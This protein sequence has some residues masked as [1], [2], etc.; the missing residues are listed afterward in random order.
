MEELEKVLEQIDKILETI[1]AINK[2]LKKKE[3]F[4]EAGNMS[5]SRYLAL[6][7]FLR[8]GLPITVSFILSK[9]DISY[10]A[11]FE[12]GLM[13]CWNKRWF[14]VLGAIPSLSAISLTVVYSPPFT[15]IYS[16]IHILFSMCQ[17]KYND[18]LDFLLHGYK[19]EFKKFVK[20]F[21]KRVDIYLISNYTL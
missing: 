16:I 15:F 10:K 21:S 12:T 6:R 14:T 17:V 9:A 18:K 13:P 8:G 4:L 5:G 20:Y 11:S 3:R 1:E 19:A 7:S 2:E